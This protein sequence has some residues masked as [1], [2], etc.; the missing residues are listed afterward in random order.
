MLTTRA[1]VCTERAGGAALLQRGCLISAQ[2][3]VT[4]KRLFPIKCLLSRKKQ[5]PDR[6]T[7]RQTAVIL[8]LQ[9]LQCSGA[10]VASV[11]PGSSLPGQFSV[12]SLAQCGSLP[13]GT[14]VGL[15][16]RHSGD[17]GTV[18]W[19]RRRGG[20]ASEVAMNVYL[21]SSRRRISVKRFS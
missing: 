13:C 20:G 1:G 8:H 10:A 3:F 14:V 16:S 19:E 2:G 7:D 6:Q 4:S 21:F 18:I 11:L 5:Q 17:G 15:H 12:S 9:L